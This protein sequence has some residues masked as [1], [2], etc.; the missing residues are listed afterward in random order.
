MSLNRKKILS[1]LLLV[2]TSLSTA[3][4]A[5]SPGVFSRMGFGARG[6][7]LGNAMIA[8]KSGENSGHYNPGMVPLL[9]ERTA[10]L[11]YGILSLDRNL[12]VLYYS[13]PIDTNAGVSFGIINSGTTDI[14]GRDIDG[15]P[16]ERYSVSENQFSLS[17]GLR[18]RKISIG[19]TTKMYYYSLFNDL[20][21]TTVG[22]DFGIVY[23]LTPRL[24]LAGVFK[25]FNTKYRWDTSKLYG[26]SGNSTIEKFPVRQAVG[27][28]YLLE[29]YDG[30]IAAE[31]E[32]SSLSTTIVRI[33]GEFM[34]IEQL[35][36]RGGIDGWNLDDANQA[37]PSFGFTLRTDYTPWKPSVNYAYILEP[38]GL[39]S[40][41]VISLTVR[42]N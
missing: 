32:R 4:M 31:I 12:N 19:M 23:P 34:P 9:K 35:T 30:L 25:D 29:E 16:T 5:G 37:H 2:L 18:I 14:D 39:F 3:Q 40:L 11:S 1:T 6:M 8:V 28:S 33:G 22:F 42:F 27:V 38:Y 10:S 7:G 26:Q 13:Q 41:H 15:F 20:S 21:S 24:T 17:F 36:I